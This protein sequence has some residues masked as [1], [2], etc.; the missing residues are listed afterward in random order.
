MGMRL[1]LGPVFAFEWLIGARRWQ[2]YAMRSLFVAGLLLAMWIVWLTEV[3]GREPVSISAQAWV[4]QYFFYAMVGTQ[5]ALVLL[6]APAATAGA[7][8][9][10]KARGTLT[11]LLVTDL[12]DGEI[13]LGKLA[14]RLVPVVGLVLC[15]LPAMSL[16]MLLGGMDPI[17]LFG[18]FLVSL[19]TA[20]LSSTLALTLSVWGRKTHEV[21]IV[22]YALLLFW[23]LG[24]PALFL[25]RMAWSVTW[26]LPTW[27]TATNPYWLAFAPYWWPGTVSLGT[28]AW[29]LL[30]TLA[31]STVL[32][33]VSTWRVRAVAA[34]QSGEAPGV[35][36]RGLLHVN[37]GRWTEWLPGPSLD[38]NPV[39]WREWHRNRATRWGRALWLVYAG[40]SVVLF[41]ILISICLEG[42]Q[43]RIGIG[44]LLNGGQVAIGFLLVAVMS[45]TSLAEERV[46]GS[47]DIL[48]ATPMPTRSIVWGKWW[49][50]YRIVLLMAVLPTL[51]S[52][53]IYLSRGTFFEA[54]WLAPLLILG[55]ILTF[56]AALTSFG[57][58]VA[59][60]VPRVG[61]AVA[62]NVTAY[63][64]VTVGTFFLGILMSEFTPRMLGAG[65]AMASPFMG[66]FFPNLM[67]VEGRGSDWAECVI[68]MLWWIIVYGALAVVLLGATL[69]TFDRSLGRVAAWSYH[70]G[71]WFEDNE[72]DVVLPTPPLPLAAD[73]PGPDRPETVPEPASLRSGWDEWI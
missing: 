20:V 18:A 39:L 35:K 48:L 53:V 55:E 72:P 32:A 47:L 54:H 43:M 33:G 3:S 25:L 71:F 68:W 59:C 62:L 56:G 9:L 15:A 58:L 51:V 31:I 40:M 4:G 41:L 64:G 45:G 57:L 49:G 6:A 42:S 19:G 11:H 50:A 13:V 7:I 73:W 44:S 1:G 22:T 63:V 65:I 26:S 38:G 61:R 5:L 66:V 12:S 16:G 24:G 21:L 17:A 46:R 70:P 8:C 2:L 27:F 69:A 23:V 36:R 60:W 52:I 30:A 10:D 14:A 34:R 67:I 37:L 29:F 28:D